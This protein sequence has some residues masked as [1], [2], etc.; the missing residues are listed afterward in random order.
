[1]CVIGRS[2]YESFQGD[3][4]KKII[5]VISL[6][7]ITPTH[8][9]QEI[10]LADVQQVFKQLVSIPNLLTVMSKIESRVTVNP[11][12]VRYRHGRFIG[13]SGPWV[14]WPYCFVVP[15][16]NEAAFIM[17]LIALVTDTAGSHTVVNP[18]NKIMFVTNIA[19]PIPQEAMDWCTK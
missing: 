8:A 4:M 11:D 9:A 14:K 7:L 6:L 15:S 5:L 19:L 10:P 16:D 12:G 2:H 17:E 18:A 3:S 13:V 1:M